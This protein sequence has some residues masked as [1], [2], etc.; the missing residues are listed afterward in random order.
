MVQVL[1]LL[2][3]FTTGSTIQAEETSFPLIVFRGFSAVIA[4]KNH[5]RF[6]LV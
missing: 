2:F 4:H 3:A 1:L 5:N 6:L